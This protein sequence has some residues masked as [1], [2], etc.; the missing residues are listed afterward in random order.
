M[1]CKSFSEVAGESD[2]IDTS[3]E[4]ENTSEKVSETTRV[5]ENISYEGTNILVKLSYY[6]PQLGGTNCS[7]FVNGVC[8]S[9]MANGEAWLPYYN[10]NTIA[11]PSQFSF[12]S[13]IVIYGEVY[14]CRDRGGAIV[15][16]DGSYW[17]DV[18]GDPIAPFGTVADAIIIN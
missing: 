8:I 7:R 5:P 4:L 13:Q 1:E 3:N 12:G 2:G 6:K 17:V 18:L 10:K 9:N 16:S 15:L 14:T 11:C